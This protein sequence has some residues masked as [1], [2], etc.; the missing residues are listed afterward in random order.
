MKPINSFKALCYDKY[1]IKFTVSI[2]DKSLMK[3]KKNVF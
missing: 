2:Y 3:C 1:L